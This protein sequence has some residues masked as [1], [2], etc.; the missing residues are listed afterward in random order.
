[1]AAFSRH[2]GID[3]SGAETPEASPKGLPHL[4]RTDCEPLAAPSFHA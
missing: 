1:M 4:I 2:I 3:Y